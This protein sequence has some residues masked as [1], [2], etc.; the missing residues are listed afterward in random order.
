MSASRR[1]LLIGAALASTALIALAGCTGGGGSGGDDKTITVMSSYEAGSPRG[2]SFETMVAAFKEETGIDVQVEVVNGEDMETVYEAAA[3]AGEQ[4]D[5]VFHNL[6]PSTSDWFQNDLVY[7][8][9]PFLDE[10]GIGD[11]LQPASIEYWT[12]NGG[13]NGFPHSAFNWP[14]WYNMEMLG[15]AG[16]T[17]VPQSVDDLIAAAQ[18]LRENGM[19]PL[20]IGGA[21]WPIQNFTTWMAQ[22]YLT[23]D[24]AKDI[25]ANGGYCESPNA[26]KGLDVLVE[27]RDNGVFVDNVAG[28]TADQMMTAYFNGDAAMVVSGSWGYASAPT[29]IAEVTELGGFPAVDGGQYDLPTAYNGYNGGVYISKSA[30]PKLDS[31]QQFIQYMYEPVNSQ[32]FV[33]GGDILA[34]TS[35]AIGDATSDLPLVTKGNQLD[36]T[37]VSFMVLPDGFWPAGYD[38]AAV[39]AEF[40]GGTESAE[41]YC[42]KLDQLYAD[43]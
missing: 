34:L 28:Y 30:E 21:E 8:V 4:P 25:F 9:G 14:L 17:E 29:E 18:A 32:L 40:L 22:Q 35:E 37:K 39:G 6:T 27:L 7:D 38:G 24:E 15:E 20:V 1:S 42:Q 19:Q 10:W 16:I 2:T 43:L 12:Q 11:K 5:M 36:E 26:I 41:E 33:G 13:V 3:L 31:I 23:P